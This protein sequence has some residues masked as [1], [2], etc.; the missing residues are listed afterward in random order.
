MDFQNAA[1]VVLFFSSG[2]LARFRFLPGSYGSAATSSTT[3]GQRAQRAQRAQ[4]NADDARN[5]RT[6]QKQ[7]SFSDVEGTYFCTFAGLADS[8]C[9]SGGIPGMSMTGMT[10]MPFPS[11]SQAR[12]GRVHADKMGQPQR[13]SKRQRHC[14]S[15]H[16]VMN[17]VRIK[18]AVVGGGRQA[19]D[20]LTPH[21]S[22]QCQ[23]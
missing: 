7:P 6:P 19:C 20:F 23:C 12:S 18:I 17:I 2:P 16:L 14:P 10:G 21:H 13:G 3:H 9:P 5:V 8:P 11:Q 1:C 22:P 15:I 4:C